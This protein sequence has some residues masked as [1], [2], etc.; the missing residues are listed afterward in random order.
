MG[1]KS[2]VADDVFAWHGGLAQLFVTP[3]TLLMIQAG[4]R[5]DPGV[6]IADKATKPVIGVRVG[7]GLVVLNRGLV[8]SRQ[9]LAPAG[10][11][12]S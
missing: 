4:Q 2:A 9:G 7:H 10:R 8:R 12:L 5:S 11:R 1:L 6:L 3:L